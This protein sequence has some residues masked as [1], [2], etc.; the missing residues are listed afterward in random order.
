MEP[1]LQKPE[2][3]L[4]TPLAIVFSGILIAGA[5]LYNGSKGGVVGPTDQAQLAAVEQAKLL[6]QIRP[7]SN[8]DH[9]RGDPNAQVKIVEYSDPECPFCKQFHSTMKQVIAEY[10]ESGKVAWVYRHFPLEQLHS[11]APNE[12]EALECANEL[13]GNDKFWQYTDRIYEITKSNNT[14]DPAELPKIA[15]FVGLDVNKFN[16]CLSSGRYSDKVVKDTENAVAIGGNG[17]PWSIVIGKGG[18]KYPINGA[19][20]LSSVKQIIEKALKGE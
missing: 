10:G 15:S 14:L 5:V 12:A 9:V 4:S 2:N 20:P 8:D 6:E 1:T 3:K 17:T 13:G 16:E 18:K 11:K 7:V 19:L